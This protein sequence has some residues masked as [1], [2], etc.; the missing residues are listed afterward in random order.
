MTQNNSEEFN[1]W[2]DALE[3]LVLFNGK[4]DASQLIQNFVKYAENKGLLE[5]NYAELPFENSISQY[6]EYDYPGDW[7][8]EEKIRHFVRW[9][10]LITVLKANK[11]LDLGG[12]I[13]TYSSASTL[14]EVGTI[15]FFREGIRYGLFFILPQGYMQGHS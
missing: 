3:N 1:D 7:G 8:L 13:S 15:I 11:E 9:N 14:Y 4:E 2:I 10:A 12:H 6:E 5:S